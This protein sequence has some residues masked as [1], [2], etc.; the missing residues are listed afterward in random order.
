MYSVKKIEDVCSIIPGQ[1]P[2]S[3]SYNTENRGLP[4]F[5]GNADFNKKHPSVR[6]WCTE[7]KKLAEPNDILISVR[8]P[9]GAVNINQVQACIGRGLAALR[10]SN[11][12]SLEYLFHFLKYQRKRIEDL[13]TGSTFKA[14]TIKTLK[15]IKIPLPPLK[16]QKQIASILDDAQALKQKTEQLLKEYD[17]LAQSIFLDMFGDPVT[18]P[19]GW[20]KKKLQN[21]L[22]KVEKIGKS[23]TA[24]EID[25]VDIAS[26]DNSKNT[27]NQTSKYN[28]D[29]RPSRAQ[30]ILKSG[31]VLFSTVRPNLKNIAI[32]RI[33]DRIASTGFFICRTKKENLN[34]YYLFELLKTKSVTNYFVS[35]TS[36]A[37]YPAIKNS[38]MKKFELI[39]PPIHL[40]NQFAEK[41]ALIEQQKDLAKQELQESEDLFQ[42]LLQKAFKGELV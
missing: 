18:N 20:E 30:Q 32:N 41:I 29:E 36:G 15:S 25:Y 21:N 11:N 19:K 28:L 14:I 8:A 22:I 5:Q 6:Y 34:N 33:D 37:N 17:E 1:S 9:V 39:V 24:K 40:Q 23:F 3:A 7:P 2:P 13:G 31:D 4:F 26:I 12:L 16:T 27:I 10:C 42:A 35:M 38:E